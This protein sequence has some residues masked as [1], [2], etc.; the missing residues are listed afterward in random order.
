MIELVSAWSDNDSVHMIERVSPTEI[1]RRVAKA[2][3][4]AFLKGTDADDI[5]A[6]K[7]DPTVIGVVPQGD[8]VR[9]DFK[10]M[11]DRRRIC[12]HVGEAIKVQSY[13]LRGSDAAVL[14][15]DV[16]PLRRLLSDAP[17]IGIGNPKAGY[18]DLE[19]DSRVRFVDAIAGKARVLSWAMCGAD[20]N[21]SKHGVLAADTDAAERALLNEFFR[22]AADYDCL[23]AW[24][25]DG[26]D[27]P[28]IKARADKVGA[29]RPDYNRWAWL[30][31]L[32]VFKKYNQ[33]HESGEERSSYKLDAVAQ[34]LLGQGK[35]DFD[36]AKTWQA[37]AAGGE[38]RDRMVRYNIQDTALLSRIEKK[39]GFVAMHIAVCKVTRNFPDTASL[40]AGQQGDGFLLALGAERGYH[41]PTK[42]FSA[43]AEFEKYDGAYVMD[44]KQT[45]AIDNVHVCDFAGLYPNIIRSWNMS[46]DTELDGKDPGVPFCVLPH[47]N[48]KF[49]TDRR[50]IFPA[51]LDTLVQKRSYYSKLGDAAEPGS[52]DWYL[53][54]SLSAGY[55]VVNNSM[56]GI[57]GSPFTRFFN[58][59]VAEGVTQTGAFL[60]KHAM[61][62]IEAAG[63][64]GI[65]G[66]TD[67]VFAQGPG[68]TFEA[69]VA[70]LNRGWGPMLAERGCPESFLKLEFEKSYKRIVLVSKKRYA[71]T[72]AKYKGKPAP[73]DMKPEIKGLEYKRG[74]TMRL[75]REMQKECIDAL[76]RPALPDAAEMREFV[77]RWRVRLLE[78]ELNL[79]DVTMS[80]SV[81]A[82]GDYKDRYTSKNCGGK[83]G[84]AKCQ[85]KWFDTAI[86]HGDSKCPVCGTERNTASHPIHVRIAKQLKAR[87]EEVH[88]G[89][90]V[91]YVITAGSEDKLS[92]MPAQ[93]PGALQS[94][95]RQYYWEH[96]VFPPTQ[97][98]LESAYPEV[99]WDAL[100]T[101]T[102]TES[103]AKKS[104]SLARLKP[105]VVMTPAGESA[106]TVVKMPVVKATRRKPTPRVIAPEPLTPVVVGA[107][108]N[109]SG[110]NELRRVV[111]RHKG[112]TPLQ[113]RIV[114]PY[115]VT[116]DTSLGIAKTVETRAALE[117]V[118]GAENILVW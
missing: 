67:S 98:V 109:K 25:G 94:I 108:K 100:L 55:K 3:W 30:D 20:G 111:L 118:V 114:D 85:H 54:K 18:F 32:L 31:Q 73:D 46:P 92:A 11:W 116:L 71:A 22:A 42:K 68:E 59:S 72:Y 4:S 19:T 9:V 90:R 82:L 74:D 65:Y 39:T 7:R 21:D 95:D 13:G 102:A 110:M 101:G 77:S 106:V 26:F 49:R 37:W 86:I 107:P 78:S 93:D 52:P 84:K 99:K 60:I 33:A 57:I 61:A 43:D 24:N 6:L 58:R 8:Y 79:A 14:E 64:K 51:A 115:V 28:V 35:H 56:Y 103:L 47:R 96:R 97:R 48:M 34:N 89:T 50:G 63:L 2:K 66:D 23:L 112:K 104:S 29:T 81:K 76:L 12:E 80:Q 36:A 105:D 17:G 5:A 1:R 53:Y 15:A 41:F 62:T 88:E 45:G 27:F 16:N 113:I 91:E 87:G 69:I 117:A 44:P 10:T 38:E 70:E 40:G 83:I 75:A